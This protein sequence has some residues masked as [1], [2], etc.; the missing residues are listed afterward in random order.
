MA[1]I[2][3]SNMGESPNQKIMGHN[4]EVLE[5]FKGIMDAVMNKTS[6][7]PELKEQVRRTSAWGWGCKH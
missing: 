5:A 2:S 3:P 1:R 4:P 7:D 6:L